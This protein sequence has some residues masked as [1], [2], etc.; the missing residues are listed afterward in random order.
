MILNHYNY[1]RENQAD[2]Y[3]YHHIKICLDRSQEW[4]LLVMKMKMEIIIMIIR[5]IVN[6]NHLISQFINIWDQII[7]IN[8]F[9]IVDL[10]KKMEL[11]LK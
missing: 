11:T 2:K 9:I 8:Y 4:N 1:K 5:M 3:M 10:F 6:Y 7:A